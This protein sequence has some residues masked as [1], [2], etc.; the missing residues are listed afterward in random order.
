MN[1]EAYMECVETCPDGMDLDEEMMRCTCPSNQYF[2]I[3][4]VEYEVD[5]NDASGTAAG[6][7][8]GTTTD[9]TTETTS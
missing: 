1:K 6:T 9:G 5:V 3:E 8:A 2:S 4:W 7:A